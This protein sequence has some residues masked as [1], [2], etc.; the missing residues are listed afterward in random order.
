M[1]VRCLRKNPGWLH[2]FKLRA[3]N[4]QPLRL[5]FTININRPLLV[6]GQHFWKPVG[7][8]PGK[9]PVS[10]VKS[11]IINHKPRKAPACVITMKSSL[12]WEIMIVPAQFIHQSYLQWLLCSCC[13]TPAPPS[14]RSYYRNML[15]PAQCFFSPSDSFRNC[16]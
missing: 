9:S 8:L 4:Q 15:V 2:S 12:V 1:G 7:D 16:L 3:A 13:S 14:H 5:L 11:S 10:Q 6:A